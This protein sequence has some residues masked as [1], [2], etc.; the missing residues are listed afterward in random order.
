MWCLETVLLITVFWGKQALVPD[1]LGS[2]LGSITSRLCDLGKLFSIFAS[3][4]S[5][6]K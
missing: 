3:N 6:L 2:K 1:S 4:F 5:F